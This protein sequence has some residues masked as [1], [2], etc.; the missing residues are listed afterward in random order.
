M[1]ETTVDTTEQ[2]PG[3]LGEFCSGPLMPGAFAAPLDERED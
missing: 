3:F 1:A 2:R